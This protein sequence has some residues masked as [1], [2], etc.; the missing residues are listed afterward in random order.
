MLVPANRA[1]EEALK[2]VNG[3]VRVTM[4][5]GKG[6]QRRRGLYWVTVGLVVPILNQMHQMT[7]T[8]DDL[9]TQDTK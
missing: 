6:N 9:H 5:G 3:T 2:D 4:T 1:A 7:L 8:E